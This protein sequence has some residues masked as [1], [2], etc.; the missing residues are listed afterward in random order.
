LAEGEIPV[1]HNVTWK[2]Y[3][4]HYVGCGDVDCDGYVTIGDVVDTYLHVV[5]PSY[6]LNSY[7]AADTDG[8]STITISDVVD[9]Y[10]H[11]IDPN[12]VLIC[13]G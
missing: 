11:V 3:S 9:T 6:Q 12:N 4:M 2:G 5:S 7:W 1:F 10:L 13:R 8:D